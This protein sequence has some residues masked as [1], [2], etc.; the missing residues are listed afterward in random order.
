VPYKSALVGGPRVR[1]FGRFLRPPRKQANES[2]AKGRYASVK[3]PRATDASSIALSPA[4][5]GASSYMCGAICGSFAHHPVVEVAEHVGVGA[6]RVDRRDRESRCVLCQSAQI[7]GGG[8]RLPSGDSPDAAGWCPRAA[9]CEL[10]ER[11]ALGRA[12]LRTCPGHWANGGPPPTYGALTIVP[13][14]P[15]P[16]AGPGQP[17][18]ARKQ[19]TETT[20][21]CPATT[22]SKRCATMPPSRTIE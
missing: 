5:F 12:G 4:N 19:S 3:R 22:G 20:R 21:F 14:R 15:L 17:C 8:R 1:G 11:A 16:F 18:A 7:H 13:S 2:A 9:G 6:D 10:L